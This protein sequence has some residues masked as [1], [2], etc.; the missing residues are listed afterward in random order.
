MDNEQGIPVGIDLGTTL[1]VI[2]YVNERGEPVTIRN[3]EGDLLTPSAVLFDAKTVT[4]GKEALK[5]AALEPDSF[6][7]FVKRDMGK[8][9]YHR[10]IRGK[11]LPPE[12]IQSLILRKLRLEAEC[13]LQ[14]PLR[15]AVITVPA[16]FDEPRRKATQ[17]AG[18][19]AGLQVL[20]IINEPT[21]AAI[22]YGLQ[23]AF[24]NADGSAKQRERILVYDL[25]GGTFDATLMQIEGS[26]YRTLATGG[27]VHLGGLDFD[28]RLVDYAITKYV[29]G[30]GT[31]LRQDP[32]HFNR[33]LREAEDV[34]RTL[35]NRDHTHFT[36]DFGG[37]SF[38]VPVTR[39][40]F[41][42]LIED[43]IARTLFTIRSVCRAAGVNPTELT[44][45]LLVG[46][47][48][49]IPL[50]ARTLQQSLNVPVQR[51]PNTDEIVAHGAA[52][53]ANL[54]CHRER[55]R[56]PITIQNVNPH[57]LGV[58]GTEKATGRPRVAVI[59]PANTPLPVTR[60]KRFST[61]HEGQRS[62]CARIVE[63]GDRT[64][65]NAT[66]IGEC[67]VRD[68]PEGL[69]KDTPVEVYFSYA[70]NGRLTVRARLPQQNR[71]AVMTIRRDSGLTDEAR[72]QWAERLKLLKIAGLEDTEPTP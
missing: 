25:G 39:A 63:G 68:L 53:Y 41:E 56:P 70:S 9:F 35:S 62:V 64:G 54:L 6:A 8:P 30:G 1:S 10:P 61:E 57:P 26:T 11:T 3:S 12:V 19:L 5:A 59:I 31:D 37:A 44:R 21:A 36:Y 27:D 40:E 34:K 60:G 58:L 22:A 52:L 38:R 69:P 16:Y 67:V 7:A 50:V 13:A 71:E 51:V 28:R 18:F 45:V 49:R 4:V 46:G 42:S 43:L 20:D 23:G 24:L 48:T 15:G 66:P 17:D 55:G 47:S 33:L 2:A 14:R 72:T 29:A 65:K 32:A